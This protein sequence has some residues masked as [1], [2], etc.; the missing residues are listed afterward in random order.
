MDRASLREG[1]VVRKLWASALD[2]G[3][4]M[5]GADLPSCCQREA[6]STDDSFECVSCG[7][8]WQAAEEP[9]AEG[10]AFAVEEERD[11]RGAA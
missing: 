8:M 10:C 3:E 2:G 9:E 11:H 1:G 6:R 7:A 4:V 5:Y